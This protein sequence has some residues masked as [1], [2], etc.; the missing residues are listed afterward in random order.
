M[1]EILGITLV[2]LVIT[3]IILLILAGVSMS[4]ITGEGGLFARANHA[5][6]RYN[7]VSYN[8]AVKFNE[9]DNLMGQYI[10]DVEDG[11]TPTPTPT[12]TNSTFGEKFDEHEEAGTSL[13]GKSINY[14]SA[15][16]NTA[17]QTAG[18][19]IILGKQ[20]NGDILITTKNP[21]GE[22][23]VEN[24]LQGW[25]EYETII[26]NACKDYVGQTGSLG[27]KA[28]TPK[29]VRS[30]K[31]EDI[32]NTVEFTGSINPVT[33]SVSTGGYAYPNESEK[34]WV[35]NM[36]EDYE[37][38]D[39]EDIYES[40]TFSTEAYQFTKESPMLGKSNNMKYV[41]AN[42]TLYWVASRA[43]SFSTPGYA[44]FNVGY[45][46]G[47]GFY[48]DSYTLCFSDEW[49]GYDW[50]INESS[51]SLALRPVV[52]LSSEIPWEDVASLI[53]ENYVSY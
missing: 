48:F 6:Y 32:N 43:V 39:N 42:N 33:I 11:E 19:W 18:G 50:E 1:E 8:E 53:S 2:A 46:A 12:P 30:I 25:I 24:T 7:D 20:A 52:V 9:L 10:G 38:N 31:M 40:Y 4:L 14:V 17:I 16:N 15:N 34:R 37:Y 21:V 51:D 36:G 22:Q 35:I 44:Y 41:L 23:L 5:G 13:I 47:E 26:N 49:E 27:G 29:Y 3:V 45:V 28:I